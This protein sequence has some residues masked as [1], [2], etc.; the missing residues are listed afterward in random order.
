MVLLFEENFLK[1]NLY[2][3]CRTYEGKHGSGYCEAEVH[4]R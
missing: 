3:F 4:N 2:M 1:Q